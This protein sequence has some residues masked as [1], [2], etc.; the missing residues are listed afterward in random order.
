M[1]TI[2]QKL[3]NDKG[4]ILPDDLLKQLKLKESDE[5]ALTVEGERLI[6]RSVDSLDYQLEEL[7][8]D[9]ESE[10]LS[11]DDYT[12]LSRS[13]VDP[14]SKV[15]SSTGSKAF[16]SFFIDACEVDEL[17]RKFEH[18]QHY[19]EVDGQKS[20]VADKW[21]K[22]ESLFCRTS[23]FYSLALADKELMKVAENGNKAI[24]V[25]I[26]NVDDEYLSKLTV[27]LDTIVDNYYSGKDPGTTSEDRQQALARFLEL[28]EKLE[29]KTGDAS[30]RINIDEPSNQWRW[31]IGAYV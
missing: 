29:E 8:T 18:F 27:E 6:I 30:K 17:L 26:L 11:E 12:W 5:V 4:I 21:K 20:S 1:K 14:K 22:L 31:Y 19:G 3:G 24:A 25:R 28:E 16:E 2:I 23:I 10:N 15:H 9:L 13:I 7:D